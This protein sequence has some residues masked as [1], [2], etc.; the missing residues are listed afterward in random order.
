M[1]RFKFNQVNGSRLNSEHQPMIK[2]I[3]TFLDHY[4]N[5]AF[6]IDFYAFI[7]L[8]DSVILEDFTFSGIWGNFGFCSIH[9]CIAGLCIVTISAGVCVGGVRNVSGVR[10]HNTQIPTTAVLLLGSLKKTKKLLAE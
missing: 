7:L 3:S 4:T 10:Q 8:M 9:T 6:S 5:Q 1:L 2:K